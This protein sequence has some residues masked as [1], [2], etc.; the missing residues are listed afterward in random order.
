M[1][2]HVTCK[3]DTVARQRDLGMKQD[4]VVKWES[5]RSQLLGPSSK[6]ISRK[7]CRS[8]GITMRTGS[9]SKLWSPLSFQV[10]MHHRLGSSSSSTPVA[11]TEGCNTH[12]V[13]SR[14]RG[15]L[16]L[17]HH[18]YPVHVSYSSRVDR[19]CKSLHK[20]WHSTALDPN[21]QFAVHSCRCV[22]VG[23]QHRAQDET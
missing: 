8:K 1:P 2:A 21:K 9:Q 20:A 5:K 3:V 11:C 7:Q 4:L 6:L 23:Q 10:E 14:H 12:N 18:T 17:Q 15:L 13:D 19:P 16:G 22:V